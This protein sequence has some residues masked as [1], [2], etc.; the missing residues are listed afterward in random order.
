MKKL[1][2][3]GLSAMA[4]VLTNCAPSA[5][6]IKEAVEKDPSIVFVAI[7]K[8]PDQFI[9][10]VNKAAQEAQRKAQDKSIAEESKKRDEEF[11]NPLK[12][13]VQEGRVIF[14]KKDAKVTIIEYSD[15]ECPYCSKGYQ[16]MKQVLAEYPNDVR[17]VFKHLP[18]DFHPQAMPAAKYFEAI[19]RQSPE[20]AQKF[21]D[22]VFE[23]QGKLRAD[24]EKFLTDSAKKLGVD[25]KKLTTDLGDASLMTR[26]NA[27][28]EEAKKFNF[29][30]TPGFLINGV[31]LRGAYPYPEFKSIIDRH[32]GKTEETKK[33]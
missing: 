6:Q 7:E 16:T 30:G 26:I 18:L 12:P 1:V 14:G 32:L 17:I 31:S 20:K 13:E 4:F 22:A 23:N 21:H 15:F 11:A 2:I 29:S 5:K 8:Y 19:A 9:E 27:D 25:M 33:Q 10:V 3:I 28:M 24:G